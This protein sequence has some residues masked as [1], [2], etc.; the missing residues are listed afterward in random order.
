MTE[1]RFNKLFSI[2]IMVGMSVCVILSCIGK[3]QAPDARRALLVIS[4]FGAIMGVASTVLSANGSLWNFLFG[5]IDVLIYSYILFDSRMP[6]QFLLH[7]LYFLPMEVIG[8][9][10]WRKRGA[11][12]KNKVKA[13]RLKGVKWLW[14]ALLFIGVYA[15]S[16]S[17]SYLLLDKVGD[18]DM[19][20]LLLDAM[21]TTCNIVALVMMAFAYLEQWYVWTLVNVFSIVLWAVTLFTHPEADYAVIPLIKYLFYFINGINGIRIWLKLSREQS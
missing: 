4:A 16:F 15:A 11:D 18:V 2:F 6:S 8:F 19:Q 10:Q 14:Y 12:G 3:M 7:V 17:V 21:V 13:Q 20:K 5:L 9:F 1:Q